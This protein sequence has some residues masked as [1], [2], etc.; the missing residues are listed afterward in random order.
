MVP[1]I[2]SMTKF[3]VILDQFLHFQPPKN[4]KKNPNFEK[5][6]QLPGDIIILQMCIINDN[7]MMHGS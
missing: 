2:W 5:I 4:Q 7:H 3:F 1:D 6:K